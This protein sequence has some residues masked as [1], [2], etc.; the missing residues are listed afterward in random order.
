MQ[1]IRK[2]QC[3]NAI[4]H[5]VTVGEEKTLTQKRDYGSTTMVSLNQVATTIVLFHT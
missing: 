4:I 1:E 3:R 5:K 2:T